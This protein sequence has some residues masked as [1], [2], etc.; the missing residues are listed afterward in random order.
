[1]QTDE[2]VVAA[3]YDDDADHHMGEDEDVAAELFMD[4]DEDM[5][6][7][8]MANSLCLAGARHGAQQSTALRVKRAP[9]VAT[10]QRRTLT[11]DL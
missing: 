9:R 2:E 11:R 3:A 5:D 7:Q 1:M 8:Q 10:C 6:V 4:D